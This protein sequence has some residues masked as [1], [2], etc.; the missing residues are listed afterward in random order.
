V[1]L[2]FLMRHPSD[3]AVPVWRL[4]WDLFGASNQLLAALTL[5][6]VT[7]WLWQTRRAW[8]VWLVTGLPTVFMYAMSTWALALMTAPKFRSESG[9]WVLPHDPVPWIGLVLLALAALMLVEAVRVLLAL[10][11]PP[12]SGM[13]PSLAAE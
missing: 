10:G 6:G 2:F 5:L 9:G 1:P 8:W 12:Q 7:V 4:F 13:R 3:A 11:R